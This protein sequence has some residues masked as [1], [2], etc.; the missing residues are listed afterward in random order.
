MG[1]GRI[2]A[3]LFLNLAAAVF[4]SLGVVAD[5]ALGVTPLVFVVAGTVF[6]LTLLAYLEGM[7]AM[8]QA[9]GAAGFTRRGLGELTSF[10][11][12]WALV[13]DYLIL[14][15]LSASFAVHYL[16]SIPGLGA[17]LELPADTVGTTIL[18]C[19]VAL[20]AAR[21][22][23]A[24][25][26]AA[27]V[28][29]LVALVAQL[30][31][32]A[33]GLAIAIEP[34]AMAT[35]V[36][37][38][39]TPS[40][41]GILFALP[42]AM[43]GFTGLDSVANLGGELDKPGRDVPRPMIWSSVVS[44]AVFVAMSAVALQAQPVTGSGSDAATK[45]ASEDGWLDRPV[46]GIVEALDVSDGLDGALR[47]VFGMLAATVLFLTANAAI[48]GV[49]RI[50]FFM[51][52]HRQA[53][54]AL[55]AIDRESGVPRTALALVTIFAVGLLVV[56][57][58]VSESA[59]VLAQVYAFGA[60]F[61][62]FVT[63]AAIIRMRFCE[64]E[65]ERPFRAPLNVRVGSGSVSVLAVAGCAASL[66]MW[67]LVLATHDTARVV[68]I[69]WMVAGFVAY[70]TYRLTHGLP[71]TTRVDPRSSVPL[72]IDA[73]SYRRILIAVRPEPG[74]LS[75]AGDAE[76]VGLAHK[77]LDQPEGE[78]AEVSVML[79]HELPLV[80]PLDAPLGDVELRSM[81]RLAAIREVADRLGLRL[82]ST[83]ARGRAA[84]RAI[85]QEAQR[86]EA[87]AVLLAIRKRKR[88]GDE[89]FGRTVTY[90]LRHA[91]CDVLVL[92]LPEET[93]Q[94][95]AAVQA[96]AKRGRKQAAVATGRGEE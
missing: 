26:R 90:V 93:L 30:L 19:L 94:R 82:S 17:L 43:I 44:V 7:A 1:L 34:D 22:V 48:A 70:G 9:G 58:S 37:L 61:T 68:G 59:I 21:G 35:P 81:R 67:V 2:A 46:I 38:G 56:T 33:L 65:L 25:A 10:F 95:A 76:I 79:V 74:L 11:A 80:Q 20:L 47:L 27:I 87:D 85:C 86:R 50:A 96:A 40:W 63:C 45:L 78:R 53:P 23:R 52:H 89:V 88:K 51:S 28:V 73:Q 6:L 31:L 18:I 91:P 13:L 60:T 83:V 12:G 64:P 4:V 75:G 57:V 72:H 55:A 66:A 15:V 54:S 29:S 92:A 84:G 24:G 36:A 39:T 3:L 62:S 42:I 14:V 69:G 77:L 32:A 8:P 49:G 5:E 71:L 41:S 16:G